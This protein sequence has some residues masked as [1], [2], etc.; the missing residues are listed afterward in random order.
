M[1]MA[2]KIILD[3]CGGSGAWSM[4]YAEAGYEVRVVSLPENDVRTYI[5]GTVPESSQNIS[6]VGVCPE[7]QAGAQEAEHGLVPQVHQGPDS[8]I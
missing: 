4:P 1:N 8:S 2:N 6:A 7:E 3:L 5:P